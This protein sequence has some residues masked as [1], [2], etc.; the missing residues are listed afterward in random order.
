VV[1]LAR[2]VLGG[3][4]VVTDFHVAK[5]FCDMEA[6]YTYEVRHTGGGGA[7]AVALKHSAA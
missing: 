6:I 2:E 7:D 5:Q 3:N 4:G 1:A